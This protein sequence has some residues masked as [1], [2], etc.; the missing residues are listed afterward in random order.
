MNSLNNMI[1]ISTGE[2]KY[3]TMCKD[4]LMN[5]AIP[6]RICPKCGEALILDD[7]CCFNCGHDVTSDG[8]E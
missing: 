5:F 1:E 7:Y 4:A 8:S 2:Y 6:R 3:L